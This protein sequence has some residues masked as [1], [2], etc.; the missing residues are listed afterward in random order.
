MVI[1]DFS[2]CLV[3]VVTSA[4]SFLS[5]SAISLRLSTIASVC[6]VDHAPNL[7]SCFSNW[8]I[9]ILALLISISAWFW[10]LLTL[11]EP[12]NRFSVSSN[13]SAVLVT[14]VSIAPDT[15]SKLSIDACADA[16][17]ISKFLDALVNSTVIESAPLPSSPFLLCIL[18]MSFEVSLF[19]SIAFLTL[20]SAMVVK[21]AIS[22]ID[23]KIPVSPT[24]RA[25]VSTVP[26]YF[27]EP[28]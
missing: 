11:S 18:A 22:F 23:A 6:T 17:A 16:A 14:I 1:G 20:P 12:R 25:K 7:S 28:F 19:E 15:V 27:F 26:T 21:F 2:F 5:S 13:I 24:A 10:P 9:L 3:N 4:F 8:N